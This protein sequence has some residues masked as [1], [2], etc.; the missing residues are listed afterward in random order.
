MRI[1]WLCSWYP[2][3][4]DSFEGDFIQRHARAVSA[5]TPLTVF[6][7]SQAGSA[8]S[9]NRACHIEQHTEGVSERIMF[10]RHLRTGIKAIDKF[11][12]NLRYF[13]SYK[14]AIREYIR[15]E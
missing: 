3:P 1:V 12:Y 5:Y 11:L 10:F 2:H 9:V 14:R 6:Y 8:V 4:G 15:K 13:R 7:T